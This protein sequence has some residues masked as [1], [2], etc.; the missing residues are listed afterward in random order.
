ML[1]HTE[2]ENTRH[3]TFR[4]KSCCGVVGSAQTFEF[5]QSER[6]KP[7]VRDLTCI[8]ASD[9]RTNT[10]LRFTTAILANVENPIENVHVLDQSVATG[11]GQPHPAEGVAW[12]LVR[13]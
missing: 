10:G 9:G 3:E 12:M 2:S 1:H 6:M 13:G 8:S 5:L 7:C 11:T 4:V